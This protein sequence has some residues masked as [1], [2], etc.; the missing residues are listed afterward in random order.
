[1]TTTPGPKRKSDMRWEQG[2]KLYRVVCPSLPTP[3]HVAVLL[4]C[5]FHASGKDCRFSVAHCQIAKATKLSSRSVKRIMAELVAGGVVHT[6]KET[7][8]RGHASERI[9]TGK[10][11]RQIKGVTHDTPKQIKGVTHGT[12]RCHP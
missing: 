9:V 10:P 2:R 1:M 6:T 3:S 12:K 4:F 8:G 11:Y 5:W 7:I